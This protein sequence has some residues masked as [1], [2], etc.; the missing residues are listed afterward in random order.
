M[1]QLL[2]DLTG[3]VVFIT[4]GGAGIGQATAIAFA[5]QDVKMALDLRSRTQQR[6]LSAGSFIRGAIYP[7]ES[8]QTAH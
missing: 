7:V 5:Q 1:S 8:G 3:Q 2:L 6:G 4:G